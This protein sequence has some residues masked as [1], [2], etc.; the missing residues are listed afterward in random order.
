MF[1]NISQ[2]ETKELLVNSGAF[3]SESS[4]EMGLS[5]YPKYYRIFSAYQHTF[6]GNQEDF[7]GQLEACPLP[8]PPPDS[9]A[10]V[11]LEMSQGISMSV[12]EHIHTW[13]NDWLGAYTMKRFAPVCLYS[14]DFSA[15]L[16]VIFHAP[17]PRRSYFSLI[18]HESKLLHEVERRIAKG[19]NTELQ[20]NEENGVL[21]PMSKADVD[22]IMYE[23]HFLWTGI[24]NSNASAQEVMAKL[25]PEM[26][27]I[28]SEYAVSGLLLFLEMDKAFT[29]EGEIQDLV[30]QLI[31]IAGGNDVDTAINIRTRE[32]HIK[33]ITCRAALIGNPKYVKGEV[34]YDFGQY[35]IMLYESDD[36]ERGHLIVASIAD[37][38]FTLS[39][40]DWG[41]YEYNSFGRTDDH[42]Y[43]NRDNTRRLYEVLH[44]R[45]PDALLRTIRERFTSPL[46]VNSDTNF[47]EFCRRQGIQFDS[48]FHY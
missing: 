12:F 45:N 20:R 2:H 47:L 38:E 40:Y 36:E 4:L 48:D 6:T 10:T 35:E 27:K 19:L 34:Y 32:S 5:L 9:R 23:H 3:S 41:K 30:Q 17:R 37:E 28:G 42:H 29:L 15:R 13:A 43:F 22:D 26:E 25:R 31:G 44:R 7:L 24:A 21:V 33:S 8:V 46:S 18:N 16:T 11:I 1:K 39:R 14:A